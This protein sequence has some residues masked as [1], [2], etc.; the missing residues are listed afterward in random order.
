MLFAVP[1]CRADRAP[2]CR[3][4]TGAGS[5]G[6]TAGGRH[7][8]D[9]RRDQHRRH[10]HA[11]AV[12]GVLLLVI[13]G[14]HGG[15]R[16]HVIVEAAVLVVEHDQ[17]RRLPERR[18][19][20]N[21]V[22]DAARSAHHRARRRS[23]D[24]DRSGRRRSSR[25]SMNA[26]DGKCVRAPRRVAEKCGHPTVARRVA[27]L[28]LV[29]EQE[30]LRHVAVVDLPES[31]PPRSAGRKRCAGCRGAGGDRNARCGMSTR[32]SDVP[33][34][35][36]NRLVQVGPGT[37]ENQRSQTVNARASAWSAGS[38]RRGK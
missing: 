18:V 35:A 11:L 6:R 4:G 9:P 28:L 20:S 15:R 34:C 14:G 16:Q 29:Q 13:V 26:K 10:A 21:R 1:R 22:V 2:T 8:R 37:D 25:G 7:P 5:C 17:Q 38:A 33:L 31:S 32:P 36:K 30:R 19:R 24:A 3:S 23:A 12:E 27:R